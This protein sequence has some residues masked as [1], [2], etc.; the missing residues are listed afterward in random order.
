M[1]FM[2]HLGLGGFH[3]IFEGPGLPLK[4]NYF[5]AMNC[6]SKEMVLPYPGKPTMPSSE[7]LFWFPLGDS[8][9]RV[10]KMPLPGDLRVA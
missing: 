7:N 1:V 9:Y 8:K 2:S 5:Q 6:K 4:V 10:C 3:C